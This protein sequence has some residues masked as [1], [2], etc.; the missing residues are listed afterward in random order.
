MRLGLI[1]RAVNRGLGVQTWETWRALN[2]AVTVVID[3]LPDR[4]AWKFYPE[5]FPD[6]IVTEWAG[7][8]APISVEATSALLSCI[9]ILPS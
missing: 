2:P 4:G 7:Y 1:V 8:T 9:C 6:A 5:R 3:S